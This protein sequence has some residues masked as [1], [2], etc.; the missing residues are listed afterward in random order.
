MSEKIFLDDDIL[1]ERLKAGDNQALTE[2]YNTY[3]KS[4]FLSSYSLLKNKEVCEDII[5]DVFVDIW[6]KRETIKIT[7]SLKAYLY[8]CTR[9]K[10]YDYFRKNK[11]GVN[12][13]L[14]ENL[15]TRIYQATP[16]TKLM[17]KELVEH[18]NSVVDSLPKKCRE[19]YILSREEQLSHKE[20]AQKLN[21]STKTIESH[22]TR[23]LKTLRTSMGGL[24][25]LEMIIWL[26]NHIN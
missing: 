8:A 20:I 17:H 19:I 16:A 23:A 1:L 12:V 5:Q 22:I 10:V 13:D 18:I 14:I 26:Q 15:N 21:I 24:V 4:L 11:K 7:I 25:S 3:W 9:Y 2:I 6:K